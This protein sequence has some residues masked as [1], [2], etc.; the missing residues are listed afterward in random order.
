MHIYIQTYMYISY[1]IYTYVYSIRIHSGCNKH[2]RDLNPVDP[3]RIS[4][5]TLS[6][7]SE[8]SK[9]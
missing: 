6:G 7:T 9:S 4:L 3:V 5:K 8:S 1:I 2:Y